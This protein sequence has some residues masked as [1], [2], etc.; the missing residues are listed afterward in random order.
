MVGEHYGLGLAL[1]R[2]FV[3]YAGL[4]PRRHL[5]TA[6]DVAVEALFAAA[7]RYNP[8]RA[9]F[10]TLAGTAVYRKL[11]SHFF[12]GRR[13][14]RAVSATDYSRAEEGRDRLVDH[15]DPGPDPADQAELA[16]ALALVEAAVR[17]LPYRERDVIEMRYRRGLTLQEA[18]EELGVS[19]QAV[20]VRESQALARLRRR[21]EGAGA[22]V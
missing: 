16:E 20:Q 17:K 6:R 14:V 7:E 2:K 1:A 22:G 13:Q 10:G 5:E 15:A 12:A 3:A 18:G 4:D 9:R 21:L 8:N 11:S 19:R